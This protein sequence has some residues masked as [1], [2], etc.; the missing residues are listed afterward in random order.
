V[1]FQWLAAPTR[2]LGSGRISGVECVL[3]ALGEP[4]ESGRRRPEPLAGS[5]FVLE[6]DTLV[7]AIGQAGPRIEVDAECRTENPKVFAGGD[8]VNGGA[9]AVEAVRAGRDAALAI[10]RWLA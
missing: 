4:D 10:D 2:V 1:H 5:E 8:V 7:R 6:C 3:M 9:S